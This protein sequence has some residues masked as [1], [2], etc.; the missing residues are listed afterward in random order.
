MLVEKGQLHGTGMTHQPQA[1][2]MALD[3]NALVTS[4]IIQSIT[5]WASGV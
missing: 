3:F 2:G 1:W 4:N 5:L